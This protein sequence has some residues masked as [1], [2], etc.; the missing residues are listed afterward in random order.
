[1]TSCIHQA[2]DAVW[3]KSKSEDETWYLGVVMKGS[4]K[5]GPVRQV[6]EENCLS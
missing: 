5:T 1:M 4:T 6:R 3:V 2:G